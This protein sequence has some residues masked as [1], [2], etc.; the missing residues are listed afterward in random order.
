MKK[1]VVATLALAAALVS[2]LPGLAA[3]GVNMQHNQTRLS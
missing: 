2:M 3:A 1:L